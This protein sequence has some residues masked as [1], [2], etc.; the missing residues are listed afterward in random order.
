LISNG[1]GS[2][3]LRDTAIAGG[4]GGVAGKIPGAGL[5]KGVGGSMKQ[6]VTGAAA[7]KILPNWLQRSYG[8]GGGTKKGGDDNGSD[9]KNANSPKSN[10][11]KNL[12]KD[13]INGNGGDK[14]SSNINPKITKITPNENKNAGKGDNKGN[15]MV[16]DA[17]NNTKPKAGD[18]GDVFD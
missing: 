10:G 9:S 1:A 6:E 4:L 7:Q 17:I 15:S 13:A 16:N 2:N 18:Y 8:R 11:D 12:A 5:L 14:K 3:E